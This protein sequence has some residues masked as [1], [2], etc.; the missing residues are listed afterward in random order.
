MGAQTNQRRRREVNMSEL[1][2]EVLKKPRL[3]NSLLK[4]ELIDVAKCLKLEVNQASRKAQI[5]EA[6]L[7]SLTDDGLIEA[8]AFEDED[9]EKEEE[10]EV[11]EEGDLE[12]EQEG[13]EGNKVMKQ[14]ELEK[15]NDLRL[16]EMEMKYRFELE[17]ERLK[18]EAQ[19]RMK[20]LD[21]K[22]A[23]TQKQKIENATQ[24]D[25]AKNIRLVPTFNEGCVNKYFTHFEKI[26]EALKWPSEQ[27]CLL[28]QSWQS[29]RSL[30][31][32]TS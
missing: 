6:V 20:E 17:K 1:L 32:N 26:A 8:S 24:F 5:K 14:L 15:E 4:K 25:I 10:E 7:H 22:L 29:T 9:E 2:Q 11:T 12:G 3:I 19:I 23:E 21:V 28:L 18:T 16:R 31:C 13:V 30:L 27:R